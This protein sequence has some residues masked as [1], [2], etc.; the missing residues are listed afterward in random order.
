MPRSILAIA[1]SIEAR[2]DRYVEVVSRMDK[3]Y[4]RGLLHS[5]A[6]AFL[7]LCQLL[8]VSHVFESGTANGQSTEVFA[9]Y[10]PNDIEITTIDLDTKYHVFEQTKAR[11]AVFE[12][13]KC[14][15]G[16]STT[17][18]P[19]QLKSIPKDSRAAIFIDGPK[20][21]SGMKLAKRLLE[22]PQV[23]FVAQHDVAPFQDYKFHS[24]V[25]QW[26]SYVFDTSAL[27]YRNMFGHLDMDIFLQG[28]CKSGADHPALRTGF[29]LVIAIQGQSLNQVEMPRF[30]NK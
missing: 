16:D 22:F 3:Y 26:D 12:N 28:L 29:G 24:A 15:L 7:T 9:R 27:W 5:E 18:I 6:I 20:G 23:A 13:V 21:H 10:L 4:D 30:C 14:V 1:K 2:S 19:Q 17:E 25:I 11:L 8:L